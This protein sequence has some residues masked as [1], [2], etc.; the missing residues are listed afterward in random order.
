VSSLVEPGPNRASAPAPPETPHA[1]KRVVAAVIERDNT[2]LICRRPEGKNHGGL[3]EFPG[4]KIDD[5]ESVGEAIAR[6]L[7][8]E[9]DVKTLSVGQELFSVSDE[10]SGYLIHFIPTQISGEPMAL[11]H[12]AV[13]WCDRNKLLDYPLAP[14]DRAFAE[15]LVGEA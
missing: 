10:L 1:Q 4:G 2:L 6:E 3:W 13:V 8:E 5:Q 11:E 14:S 7:S 9:L 12:S 15:Y